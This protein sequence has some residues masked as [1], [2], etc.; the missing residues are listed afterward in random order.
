MVLLTGHGH[1]EVARADDAGDHA[2]TL[3]LVLEPGALLDVRLGVTDVAGGVAALDG[4]ALEAR[5]PEGIAQDVALCI[6]GIVGG[7]AELAAEGVASEAAEEAALLVDPG[8]DV[9]REVAGM[10]A[11]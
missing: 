6:G 8:S 5:L 3:A 9:D 1:R 11:L 2:D 7:V 4:G 10:R